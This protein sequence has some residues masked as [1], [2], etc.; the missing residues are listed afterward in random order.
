MGGGERVELRPGAGD[1]RITVAGS[2]P[3]RRAGA[4]SS[5]IQSVKSSAVT[6]GWYCT[7]QATGPDRNT[8]C[9]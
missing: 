6:S 7:P 1:R 4:S 2:R 8:W 5:R 3:A 9:G